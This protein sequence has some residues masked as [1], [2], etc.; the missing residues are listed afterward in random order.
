MTNLRQHAVFPRARFTWLLVV[1]AALGVCLLSAPAV[2]AA[3]ILV[4]AAASLSDALTEI[5]ANF[6]AQT[7]IGVKFN[8]GGSSTLARQIE[9]GAPAD[10]FFS[11]DETQMDRLAKEALIDPATRKSLLGNTLVVIVPA[12]SQLRIPSAASLTNAAVNRIALA[13]PEAVPAGVYARTWLEKN[14]LWPAI[15]PKVVP[16]ENVRAALAAVASGNVDAGVVYKTDAA[17][18]RK[19]K[20]AC[21]VPAGEGPNISYPVALLTDAPK[22]AAAKQ[23]LDYLAG[24]E[25]GAVFKRF[26]FLVSPAAK[27]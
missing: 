11:A 25:A 14:R 24:N 10:I 18:S 9:A 7:G 2:A 16:A 12:D 27:R 21:E 6:S 20:M 1:T 5:G 23:F 3:Q 8:F 22:P 13:D 19:V 15:A 4:S 17:I 26:G